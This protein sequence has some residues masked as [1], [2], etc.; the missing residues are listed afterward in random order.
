MSDSQVLVQED[1]STKFAAPDSIPDS[2]EATDR[3]RNWSKDHDIN[4]RLTIPFIAKKY[5][6]T[7]IAGT[8]RR[9]PKRRTE[10]RKKHPLWS[11]G[12]V[13]L[14][15]IVGANIWFLL[16]MLLEVFASIEA[17]H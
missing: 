2:G 4:I 3:S 14:M 7:I 15:A 9:S 16:N 10:E 12:N 13:A 8:E 6:V 11:I 17:I 1:D 5:Y